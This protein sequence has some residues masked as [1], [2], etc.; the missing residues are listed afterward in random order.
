MRCHGGGGT[1]MIVHVD[2]FQLANSMPL[3]E[4]K[5]EDFLKELLIIVLRTQDS[6]SGDHILLSFGVYTSK[7]G[8][9]GLSRCIA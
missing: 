2:V 1:K 8:L 5:E 6:E 4:K 3:Q 7:L 9:I